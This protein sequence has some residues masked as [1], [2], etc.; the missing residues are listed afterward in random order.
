MFIKP[1]CATYNHSMGTI[2]YYDTVFDVGYGKYTIT[3]S[4]NM[5]QVFGWD[6]LWDGLTL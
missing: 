6:G 1:L 5:N 4:V 2:F 3:V